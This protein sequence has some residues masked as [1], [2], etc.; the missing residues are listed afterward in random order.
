MSEG[1][2][3]CSGSTLFLKKRFG[4][5]Y[6]LRITKSQNFNRRSVDSVIQKYLPDAR[7]KSEI[8]TEIIYAL[9]SEDKTKETNK[10]VFP[11]LFDDLDANKSELGIGSYGI[12]VTTMEDVFIK[13]GSPH[14]VQTANVEDGTT[15]TNIDQPKGAQYKRLDGSALFFSRVKGLLLK[16][17]HFWRR[18]WPLF[19]FQILFPVLVYIG[20]FLIEDY[21]RK[22]FEVQNMS[23]D[24]NINQLYPNSKG[25]F[26]SNDTYWQNFGRDFYLPNARRHT[27]TTELLDNEDP[28]QW[29]IK[30]AMT[31]GEEQYFR[32]Y[33]IGGAVKRQTNGIALEFWWNPEATHSFPISINLMYESL[34]GH[35]VPDLRDK[36]TILTRNVPFNVTGDQWYFILLTV[37]IICAMILP[38][39]A[40][41]MTAS[42]VLFPIHERSSNSKFLQLMSG[43][44]ATTFWLCNYL[45]DITSH[46][47]AI[48][49]ITIVIYIMDT[50]SIFFFDWDTTLSLILLLL[51]FGI[52]SIAMAYFF[53]FLFRQP[54]N[55]FTILFLICLA[56]GFFLHFYF[57][58]YLAAD[59]INTREG[60]TAFHWMDIFR[61]VPTLSFNIGISR[62][63][64]IGSGKS[65]CHRLAQKMDLR[66]KCETDPTSILPC[67]D[68]LCGIKGDE[69]ARLVSC[70]KSKKALSFTYHGVLI[71]ICYLISSSIL[72][73]VLVLL[74][75]G[76]P[77]LF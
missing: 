43:L 52:A 3:K 7:V 19:L 72:F 22:T 31:V 2:L 38:L 30:E 12:S 46:A 74:C 27:M 37:I 59:F 50:Y 15:Q 44:S 41:L 67:C 10:D 26:T 13:V 64:L 77:N 32:K 62:I 53:S 24:L 57:L 56:I 23:L 49:F 20:A 11:D 68:N 40:P 51:I 60:S 65:F 61:L 48:V 17:W 73:F 33:V 14:E 18:Y 76:K 28:N 35:F 63:Y 8:N 25:F 16:R 1:R 36:I 66:D 29:L 70:F 9:E 75:E 34:I 55:G 5:G 71:D 58:I 69:D 42:Y 54:P 39:A 45:W 21:L 6:H 4:A 47:I